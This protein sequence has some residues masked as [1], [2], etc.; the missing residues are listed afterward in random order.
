MIETPQKFS[1]RAKIKGG[2][3]PRGGVTPNTSVC[4]QVCNFVKVAYFG[5][6]G[7]V[8]YSA[9]L[10]PSHSPLLYTRIRGNP[11]LGKPP[12]LNFRAPRKIFGGFLSWFFV[13]SI[14]G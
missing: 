3:L 7:G 4:L 13:K 9:T 12:P 5:G 8:V 6:R 2:V 14:S 10:P 11:P 1:R